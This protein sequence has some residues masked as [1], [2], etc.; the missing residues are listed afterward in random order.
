[1]LKLVFVTT[2]S[3]HIV[4]FSFFLHDL[5]FL[6]PAV[7]EQIFIFITELAIL[8]ETPNS[9]ANGQIENIH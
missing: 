5:Y 6:I 1:M 3:L 4:L 2:L 7:N 9:K 8:I